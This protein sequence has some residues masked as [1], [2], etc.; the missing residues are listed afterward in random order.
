[1][2]TVARFQLAL[3][4][5][6]PEIVIQGIGAF[7]DRVLAEH[8]ATLTFGYNGRG[9]GSHEAALCPVH[10][11]GPVGLLRQY[12]DSSPNLEEIFVL[13]HL[14]GRDDN[15]A[16][17]AVQSQCI[18][19]ILHCSHE[20]R[21]FQRA[22]VNRILRECSK[23]LHMQLTSGNTA[24]VHST[25]GL[26]V[27]MCR[28]SEQNCRDTYQRLMMNSASLGILVQKGKPVSFSPSEGMKISTDNRVMMMLLLLTLLRGAD[29]PMA[30]EI[31]A[32]S[33]LLRKVGYNLIRDNEATVSLFLDGLL[34]VLRASSL[35]P[36]VKYGLV[37]LGVL[38]NALALYKS[39]E[40]G[41][42][43]LAHKFLHEFCSVITRSNCGAPYI[44]AGLVSS[45]EGHTDLR[46]RE[47]R[48][49]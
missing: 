46:Q 15:R 17:S 2:T 18:A 4:H 6:N 27:E 49:C 7:K 5:E 35:P 41:V 32:P 42:A 16:L 22:L 48:F 30:G 45:S 21:E 40:E 11:K 20:Q 14:P 1:M 34:A 23:S 3:N 10:P 12:I 31:F 8:G 26:I 39:E 13:W 19:V 38:K 25:I 36:K 29:A 24:L 44:G 47:V 37:D 43:D 33:S 28:T 9:I